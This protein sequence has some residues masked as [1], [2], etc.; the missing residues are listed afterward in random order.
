VGIRQRLLH[1][2]GATSYVRLPLLRHPLRGLDAVSRR[3]A[4]GWIGHRGY[5]VSHHSLRKLPE[6]CLGLRSAAF[7]HLSDFP[8]LAQNPRWMYATIRILLAQ[9]G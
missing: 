6:E 3:N 8:L 1:D 7:A 4:L 9:M 2:A 5:D